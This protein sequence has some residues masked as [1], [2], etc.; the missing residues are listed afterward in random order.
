M[1]KVFTYTKLAEM[2]CN[3][4]LNI[5]QN[6]SNLRCV[7]I[8]VRKSSGNY[9]GQKLTWKYIED[10]DEETLKNATYIDSKKYEE[11]ISKNVNDCK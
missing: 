4:I 8:G 7:C 9:N 6:K 10:V 5:K 1:N 2:Y 3:N 11:L